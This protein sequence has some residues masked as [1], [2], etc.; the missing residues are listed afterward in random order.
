MG[1]NHIWVDFADT[2]LFRYK[3]PTSIIYGA[4]IWINM[5]TL[6]YGFIGMFIF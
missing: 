4:L 5:L 3:D 1:E 2:A 6:A